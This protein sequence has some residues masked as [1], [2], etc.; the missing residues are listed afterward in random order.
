MSRLIIKGLPARYEDKHLRELCAFSGELQV[1]DAKVVRTRDGRSRQF[2]FVGFLTNQDAKTAR[3]RLDKSYVGVSKVVVDFAHAIGADA[4][5]RPWS[6]HSKGSSAYDKKYRASEEEKRKEFLRKEK[7]RNQEIAAKKKK[8]NQNEMS[9]KDRA[10][11]HEFQETAG[12][13]SS[14]PVWADGGLHIEKK[15]TMVESRKN[16][17]KGKLL[18]RK[19]VTFNLDDSDSED[20]LYDD[21]P[22]NAVNVI[23]ENGEGRKAKEDDD[24][25]SNG[26]SEEK[27]ASL[28]MNED[29]SDMDYFKSKV[30][31]S[32]NES[33]HESRSDQDNNSS[34]M[35]AIHEKNIDAGDASSNASEAES[36][37]NDDDNT[38]KSNSSDPDKGKSQNMQGGI[39]PIALEQEKDQSIDPFRK[40]KEA[41]A[42]V[43]PGDTGR[44][45]VRNLAYSVTEEQIEALF[46][47][48]GSLSE[49][50]IVKDRL[51]KKPWGMAFVQYVIPEHAPKAMLALDGTFH[52]GRIIHVL[53]AKPR[54]MHIA[55]KIHAKTKGSNLG[56][57]EFKN[58]REYAKKEDAKK[59]LDA[60]AQHALHMSSDAVA[61]VIADRN[62]VSKSDLYGLAQGESGIAA[63]RLTMG[64]AMLQSETVQYLIDNGIDLKAAAHANAND[65]AKTA[66]ARKKRLSRN[67]FLAKNLPARSN[68]EDLRELFA[69]HGSLERLLLVPS[70]LLAV[71]EYKSSADAKRAYNSLAYSKFGDAP[72]YLEWL[73]KEA[74]TGEKKSSRSG[75]NEN[76]QQT[77][78]DRKAVSSEMDVDEEE[79]IRAVTVYVKNL[80][81][82]TRDGSLLEHFQR[83]LRK[84]SNLSTQLR[85]ARVA[86]KRDNTNKESEKLSMG[87]GFLE[88]STEEGAKN[89][90]KVAQNTMLDGHA[91]ELRLSK[92]TSETK[93]LKKRKRSKAGKAGPK[94]LIRNVAF[95][96]T[97]QDIRSLFSSFGQLK[98][99]R[100]PRKMDGTHRGFAFVE[101]TTKNEAKSAL[102][103]LSSAHLYG[104]HLVI[105]YADENE[106]AYLS[107]SQLQ[108]KAAIQMAKKKIKMVKGSNNVE[109]ETEEKMVD[110]K[111]MLEDQLYG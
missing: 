40:K 13:R 37:E 60:I 72:L 104:R 54:P 85:S 73:P 30:V 35:K 18:E 63:V 52:C 68:Q 84:H 4:I 9:E 75:P 47:K 69:K 67:A 105:E 55:A 34:K 91:L 22:G 15:S 92:Q 49:V 107:V 110:Q 43:N 39:K 96:A 24:P 25:V 36:E 26:A 89:A 76:Q 78:R 97:R 88:F 90:V 101:F 108:A 5:P 95:Q 23:N 51:T 98:K 53:P 45:M 32:E 7:K 62:N 27:S 58:E 57:T 20:E 41:L 33:N 59:G 2:G 66:A 79:K 50:H 3:T 19:H 106:D 70:G 31:N 38:R 8:E 46:E 21:L 102:D 11:F 28:A 1:T 81:F 64:E 87:F 29:I 12:K 74:L 65:N 44:L 77:D 111:A 48:F 94:L 82:S 93:P 109:D 42:N 14:K 17:G 86:M 100:I 103:T 71:V 83:I 16:G 80:N 10:A 6:K 99:V 61:Q 56:E